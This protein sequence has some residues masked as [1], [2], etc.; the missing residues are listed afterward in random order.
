MSTTGVEFKHILVP[1][2]FNEP[3][4]HAVAIALALAEKFG[5]DVTL[6][7]VYYIPRPVY[8][9]AVVWPTEQLATSAQRTLDAAVATAKQRYPK[10]EGVLHTGSPAE[11]IVEMAKDRGS[12]IIV[13]G[14]HGRSGL[15][16]ALL[17]SV[18]ERVV[19][20]SPVPVL[21]VACDEDSAAAETRILAGA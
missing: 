18:A 16:H 5:A 13:M 10:C 9:V 6:L 20:T 7:H 15:M 11:R 2:D 8:D 21:T 19:R 17:G 1:T 3:A 14:T 12:D 4:N